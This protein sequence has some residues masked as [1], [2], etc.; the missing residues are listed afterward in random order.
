MNVAPV[1]PPI[2]KDLLDRVDIRV[3]TIRS[4]EDVPDSKKLA[5]LTV[6]L[7]DR[8][9]R[10]LAGIRGERANPQ[11]LAGRQAL[12]VVN[13]EPRRMAGEVSEGMLFDI[14]YA[15]GVRPVLAVPES[16]VENGVRAG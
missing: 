10:V 12:F 2:S 16:A 6:D 15:D 5:R 8:R 7:G 3:G 14:G 9:I 11:E 13:L 1:K 4:V